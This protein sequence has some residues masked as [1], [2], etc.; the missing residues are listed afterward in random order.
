MITKINKIKNFGVFADFKGSTLPEFKTFNLIY[1]WNY[2]GKTTL[3]RVF[4]CME[5]GQLHGDYS[6]ATFEMENA[7]TKYDEKF[8]VKPNIRVFNSDFVKENLKWDEDNIEPIFLL[9]IENIEL[10]T[11]LKQKETDLA[12]AEAELAEANKLRTEKQSRIN[13]SVTNK[14]RDI[15]TFLGIRAFDSRHFLPIV[16]TVK[17][18]IT[19]YTLSQNDFEKY[20]T[21]ALSNEQKPPIEEII[22]S[23]ADVVTLKAQVE[24]LLQR[25]A[26]STNKIQKLL[27][28]KPISD[29]V[30]MGKGLHDEKT[31]CEFCGNT[32]PTD[33]LTKLNEHFSKDYDQLKTDIETKLDT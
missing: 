8:E 33:L 28:S 19:T 27:D 15:G 6:T 16:E 30:E 3:S 13:R 10:Q 21:L 1:G 24:A 23:I 17:T 29:W 5:K 26:A 31:E 32:L 25:Q 11:E 4:R 2:S 9:G 18:S 14:A 22:I 20:K 7:N 12:T